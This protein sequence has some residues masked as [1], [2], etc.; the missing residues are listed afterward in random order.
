MQQTSG[1]QHPQ[2]LPAGLVHIL[3]DLEF[4]GMTQRD[5]K[6]CFKT[7]TFVDANTLK[8]AM[9][10]FYY[11]ESHTCLLFTL[12]TIVD[13]ATRG[14][15]DYPHYVILLH[16]SLRHFAAGLENILHTYTQSKYPAVHAAITI[17][18]QEVSSH[19]PILE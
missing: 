12:R 4:I 7:R 10:R 9:Y 11:G 3:E 1:T 5:Q 8:G 2:P 15:N 13:S 19:L 6:P 17:M 16:N 18:L 14:L